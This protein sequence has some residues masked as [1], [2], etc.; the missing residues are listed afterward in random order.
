M[1]PGM[2]NEF[3]P[4]RL[5]SLRDRRDELLGRTRMWNER[6]RD[7]QVRLRHLRGRVAAIEAELAAF[8]RPSDRSHHEAQL[9]GIQPDLAAAEADVANAQTKQDAAHAEWSSQARLYESCET[10]AKANAVAL[11]PVALAD[12]G[13]PQPEPTRF[14]VHE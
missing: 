6:V 11:P 8:L 13:V 4:Q 5:V 7:A 14:T 12:P 3:D 1:M 2:R 9:A 10:F